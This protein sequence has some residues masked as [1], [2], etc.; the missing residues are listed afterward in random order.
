MVLFSRYFNGGL[1]VRR[2]IHVVAALRGGGHDLDQDWS[3]LASLIIDPR[4][5]ADTPRARAV[6]LRAAGKTRGNDHGL[7]VD[8]QTLIRLDK[9]RKQRNLTEYSGDLIPES[10]VSECLSEALSLHAETLSW[11]TQQG[12][13][14]VI[15]L[16]ADA[17][18]SWS[19]RG[20]VG[21]RWS[22][23]ALY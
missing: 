11:L 14:V 6:P 1:L 10:A 18:Q 15:G 17:L 21:G 7:G 13:L 20:E 3:G 8:S 9:L 12:R 4:Q 19:G 22:N 2:T 16:A 5:G 23:S